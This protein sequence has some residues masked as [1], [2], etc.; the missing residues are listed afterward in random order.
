MIDISHDAVHVC[1]I[2]LSLLSALLHKK[3]F[4]TIKDLGWIN[5]LAHRKG[6][7]QMY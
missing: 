3:I 4:L 2:L 7:V 6:I 1:S 5:V